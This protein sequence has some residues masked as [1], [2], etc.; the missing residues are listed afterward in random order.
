MPVAGVYTGRRHV[1]FLPALVSLTPLPPI[2][3]KDLTFR[4]S[5]AHSGLSPPCWGDSPQ[6]RAGSLTAECVPGSSE[7]RRT[8][9]KVCRV[10]EH[11]RAP[12][13]PKLLIRTERAKQVRRMW[14]ETRP[15]SGRCARSCPMIPVPSREPGPSPPHV[16]ATLHPGSEKGAWRVSWDSNPRPTPFRVAVEQRGDTPEVALAAPT[17]GPVGWSTGPAWSRGWNTGPS[18][19]RQRQ[20]SCPAPPLSRTGETGRAEALET[21]TQ[22]PGGPPGGRV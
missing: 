21:S 6:G 16:G 8:A 5:G 13:H 17:T 18:R 10:L 11:A 15:G 22:A 14:W 2:Q 3:G 9:H 1:C 20:G 19:L 4:L 12:A 7:G